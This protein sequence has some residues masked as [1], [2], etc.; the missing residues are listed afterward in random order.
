MRYLSLCL[1]LSAGVFAATLAGAAPELLDRIVAV[2][3]NQV[4]L[5]SEVNFRVLLELQQR[6]YRRQPNPE[7]LARLRRQALE[8]MIDENA[9]VLKAQK[10]SLQLDETQ[11]E[12]LLNERLQDIKS[13]MST[14]EFADMLARAG[15]SERQLKL[16]YRKDIRHNLLYEQM[17]NQVAYRLY[18]GHKD[19]E[20]FRQAYRDSLPP[21]LSISKISI[22][23]KPSP[24]VLDQARAKIEEARQKLLAGEDFASVARRYSEDPGSAAGGGDL[25]C[26]PAGHLVPE[27]EEAARQLKPGQLSEPVLSPYGYHLILLREKREDELCA[28]H[29]LA[30]AAVSPPDRERVAAQL[31]ELR[32]RA[33]AGEDFAQLAKT[34]S[35]DPPSAQRGGLWQVLPKDQIPPFL[36]P[37]LGPLK[38]GQISAPF[39]LEDSGHLLKINDDQATLEGL[40]RE[41]RLEAAMRKLIDEYRQQIHIEQ[42]LSEDFLRQPGLAQ[43]R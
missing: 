22:A 43:P 9:L 38:L 23:V 15:L 41:E 24:Q 33:L 18:I 10:D 6:G 26:F 32:Q 21:R 30:Q 4:I 31:E 13:S 37:Y 12:S 16:R 29:I 27:F 5:W 17:R 2:V 20:A 3:D 7:E 36:Q 34:F 8:E 19:V 35:E 11:V 14:A 1:A 40:V 28:S 39:F 25:G 42:R